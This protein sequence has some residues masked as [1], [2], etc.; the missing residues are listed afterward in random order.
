MLENKTIE[1]TTGKRYEVSHYTTSFDVPKFS[2]LGYLGI[3][4]YTHRGLVT[5]D[6]IE[7]WEQTSYHPRRDNYERV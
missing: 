7:V 1:L 3:L 5:T 4:R 6:N 2:E